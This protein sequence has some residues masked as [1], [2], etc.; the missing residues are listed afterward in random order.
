MWQTT[1]SL[2]TSEIL[3]L[4][5]EGNMSSQSSPKLKLLPIVSRSISH[6]SEE[7]YPPL[8]IGSC[9]F[10]ENRPQLSIAHNYFQLQNSVFGK[11]FPK[12]LDFLERKESYSD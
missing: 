9:R 10:N 7:E 8:L 12:F 3:L 1:L 4:D 5:L 2:Q 11:H 6:A